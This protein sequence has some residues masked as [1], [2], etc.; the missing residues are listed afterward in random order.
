MEALLAKSVGEFFDDRLVRD[1]REG[2]GGRTRGLGRVVARA[3]MVNVVPLECQ[4]CE[5]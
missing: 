3:T 1:R 4:R 2:E 5:D